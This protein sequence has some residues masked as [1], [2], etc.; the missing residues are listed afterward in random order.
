MQDGAVVAEGP[1]T[2]VV[3]AALVERVFG[4]RCAVIDDPV[5]G[6]PLVLPLPSGAAAL[7]TS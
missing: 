3:D 2:E 6:S 5:T 4:L 7:A 1:P